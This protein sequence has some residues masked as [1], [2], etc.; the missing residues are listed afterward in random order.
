MADLKEIDVE[1]PVIAACWSEDLLLRANWRSVVDEFYSGYNGKKRSDFLLRW[2]ASAQISHNE[3]RS[4]L[5]SLIHD[6]L[7]GT[8]S[9]EMNRLEEKEGVFVLDDGVFKTALKER[10]PRLTDRERDELVEKVLLLLK[11]DLD[12]TVLAT[13]DGR[14]YSRNG[15]LV[16]E[17]SSEF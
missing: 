12:Q 15:A 6:A 4:L 8:A 16:A 3:A 10:T 1:K 2:L 11:T 14:V 13:D 7:I 17:V 9:H 5:S